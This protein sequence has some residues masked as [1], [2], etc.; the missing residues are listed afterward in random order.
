MTAERPTA[1]DETTPPARTIEGGGSPR[2]F[3]VGLAMLGA[4]A[5]GVFG[6]VTSDRCVRPHLLADEGHFFVAKRDLAAGTTVTT[7]SFS[8]KELTVDDDEVSDDFVRGDL[9][10][11]AIDRPI[12]FALEEGEVL[13]LIHVR[14]DPW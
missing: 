9:V 7:M 2:A 8:I 12:R 6:F 14:E 5:G 3:A 4:L 11:H 13:R 10:R 1:S